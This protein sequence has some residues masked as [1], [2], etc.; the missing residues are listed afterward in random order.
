MT[1][2]EVGTYDVDHRKIA[3]ITFTSV[4]ASEADGG[5]EL[6]MTLRDGRTFSF[7]A[8][9][10]VQIER[11]MQYNN[12]LSFVDLDTLIVR[13][14]S[15]EAILHAL[16]QVVTLDVARFGLQVTATPAEQASAEETPSTNPG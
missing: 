14:G 9:T 2:P 16:E 5:I 4:P 3:A 11:Q 15:L 12:W 1:R 13:E 6:Y 8:Y 10:P 7:T